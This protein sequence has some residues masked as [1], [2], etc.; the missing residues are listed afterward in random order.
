MGNIPS[1]DN[2]Y[3]YFPP[4]FVRATPP[5]PPPPPPPPGYNFSALNSLP[6]IP[7]IPKIPVIE[8]DKS[9]P[10]VNVS[11]S[12]PSLD[13]GCEKK[14]TQISSNHREEIVPPLCC[15]LCCE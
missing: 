9:V 6:P 2:G 13:E 1:Y 10:I 8:E 5:P 11:Q 4:V 3:S 7:P 14:T 15:C 12:T